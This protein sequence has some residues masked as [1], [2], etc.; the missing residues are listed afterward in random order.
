MQRARS[1]LVSIL[2]ALGALAAAGFAAASPPLAPQQLECVANGWNGFSVNVEGRPRMVL[3]KGPPGAWRH[4]A[5]VAMHGGGG[6]NFHWCVAS[7]AMTAAQVRFSEM[8]VA[9]GFAVFLLDSGDEVTD[10]EGRGCG[11]VWDDEVR[12]RANLDLPFIGAVIAEEIPAHRPAG[13]A[14]HVFLTGLSSG[15]YM[16]TRAGTHL[17]GLVS[18]VAPVS[19]GDPY[20]WHRVCDAG[21]SARARVHGVALDNDTGRR[22]SEAGACESSH[23]RHEAPWDGAANAG[24]PVFRLFHHSFDGVHDRS[25]AVRL[26]RQLALRGYR[27]EPTFWLQGDGR[28]SFANHLWQDAYNAPLLEFFE[29]AGVRVRQR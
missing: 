20:G 8:A 22:I 6:R 10:R 26:E 24:S 9:R 23:Y 2:V 18:A 4:G 19:S 3:W 11:K 12:A 7:S 27:A 1:G 15:G 16:A 13:S 21:L 25:C 29:R 14:N 28:R 17:Q 5:I